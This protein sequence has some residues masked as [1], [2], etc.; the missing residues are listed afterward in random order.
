MAHSGRR[1]ELEPSARCVEFVPSES[2]PTSRWSRRRLKHCASR[3]I[4]HVR[5]TNEAPVARTQ[6]WLEIAKLA[7]SAATPIVVAILGILLL[8][9]I[10]GVKALVARQSDFQKKWADEFVG[11]CHSFM[12]ALERDLALLTVLAGLNDPNGQFG[13]ELQNQISHLHPTL[14]ELELRIRR[15]VVFAPVRGAAVTLAA[16]ECI[17]LVGALIAARKGSVDEI[18]IEMNRFNLAS[19]NAHAEMLGLAA[20]GETEFAG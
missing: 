10:E 4:V 3:L 16:G 1:V 14:S 13:T 5:Q 12:Q 6:L 19:R 20:R 9:R 18:I 8:R 15:S 2:P 11:C 7:T 17:R